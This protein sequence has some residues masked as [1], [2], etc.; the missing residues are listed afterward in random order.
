MNVTF[1]VELFPLIHY[2][3]AKNHNRPS[4][5]KSMYEACFN[6]RPNENTQKKFEEFVI[7]DVHDILPYKMRAGFIALNS[8]I[9]DQFEI[10]DDVR[11]FLKEEGLIQREFQV[12]V[13]Y[14]NSW[15][16]VYKEIG[17]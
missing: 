17:Q 4:C 6:A 8:D 2:I 16:K 13:E 15:V 12:L 14:A 7:A 3:A 5:W 10:E 9:A 11:R 1:S